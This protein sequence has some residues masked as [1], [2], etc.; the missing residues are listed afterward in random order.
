[1]IRVLHVI[2]K[3]DRGGAETFIM[4]AYRNIDRDAIQFDFLVHTEEEGD[5]DDEIVSLGGHIY[6]IPR[7]A[8]YNRK[9]YSEAV[10]EF[11]KL[12]DEHSIVHG[13]IGS[14]A[15]IYLS[16]ARS[17]GRF[18]IA[19]SHNDV[20]ITSLK[21]IAY[22]LIAFPVRGKADYYLACSEQ[23]GL[24]RFGKKIAESDHYQVVNNGID[25]ELYARD[26]K[27]Q[28]AARD[29]LFLDDG[30]IFGHVGRLDRVKNHAFLFDVFEGIKERLPDAKLILAGQG[31]LESELKKQVTDR[32]LAQSI[33]FLGVRNDVP[34]VLKSMD[35]F[36]FPSLY[37]G[38]PL[39][40]LEA[41]ATGLECIIS[42]GVSEAA[43]VTDRVKRISINSKDEWVDQAVRSY[44]SSRV[45][46]N[47]RVETV[48]K[49][50]FDMKDVAEKLSTFY[51]QHAHQ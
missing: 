32:G 38:M 5:Y 23:A 17:L 21:D 9:A 43:M 31:P 12:H 48:R 7:Y 36:L 34:E 6:Q 41:Q 39:A 44:E 49:S 33:E 35:V 16:I 1:M 27:D 42:T 25:C 51:L 47:D 37:E 2:G 8:F 50:G 26:R 19:H 13:H 14:S 10:K 3:M 24:N 18:A 20:K 29:R 22:R 30:P 11:M 15:P 45:E 46:I 4:N 40:L 28:R